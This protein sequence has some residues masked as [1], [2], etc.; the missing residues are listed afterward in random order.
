MDSKRRKTGDQDV[1][2]LRLASRQKYLAEREAQQ[3]ALLRRQVAEEA[4]EEARLGNKLSERERAE[5][6][7]NRQTLELAE[8]RN[9]IDDSR[10]QDGFHFQTDSDNP[11]LEGTA[12]KNDVLYRR[13]NDAYDSRPQ[14]DNSN[15]YMSGPNIPQ[16]QDQDNMYEYVFDTAN[17]VRFTAEDV[18]RMDPAKQALEAQLNAAEKRSLSIQETRQSLPIFKYRQELLDAVANH[19]T[20][21]MVGDTGSGKSTQ[22]VQ[23]LAEAGYTKTGKICVT[24]PRRVAAMSVAKR[25]AEEYG[26]KIG[27]EVGFAVRFEDKTSEKTV[28]KFATD[29]ILLREVMAD[30]LLMQYSVIMIDEA[31][32]RSIASDL[33]LCLCREVCRA[34]PEFKLLILSATINATEFSEYF[35]RAPCFFVEGRNFPIDIRYTVAP[36]ANYLAAACTTALQIHLASPLDHGMGGILIFL[37]GEEEILAAVE[38]LETTMKKLGS[39]VPELIVRP[40]YSALSSDAQA[41]VFEPTPPNARL[42][43]VSTNIAETSLTIDGIKHVIDCGY[44]KAQT[45]DPVSNVSS[46]TISPISRASANQRSGRAGRT[47]HGY[48]Y[49]LYTKHAF[50]NELPEQTEPELLRSNLD[51]VVLTLKALNIDNLLEFEFFTAPSPSS[52]IRSLESLYSLAALDSTG[53]LTKLGR[54]MAELPLDIRLSKM[55]LESERY[56]CQQQVLSIISVL[57]EASSLF[58][59]PKDKKVAADAARARFSSTEGGD[60][61][62]YLNIW[63]QYEES[64]FDSRWATENFLQWRCLSRARNV[65][66]QLQ[67]L[68]DRVEVPYSSCGSTDHVAIR[69]CIT[70]AYFGNAARL[71]RDGLSYRTVSNNGMTV[72]I[73]PSSSLIENRPK[74]IVFYEIVESSKTYVRSVLPIQPEWLVEV[75]PH[76]HTES[77][78]S[79]LGDNK[80]MPKATA[81]M[82]KER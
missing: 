40:L 27:N 47:S 35:D 33:L 42:V 23:Y 15:D 76:M 32:E 2:A 67:N 22:M 62:T 38:N 75:A 59:R 13:H 41:K 16:P 58:L 17:E 71:A 26:C 44:E 78:I 74:W 51:G 55:V 4:E 81:K 29:G 11:L 82:L 43:V 56:Q 68:C 63:N 80:K 45:Y 25:V 14:H 9:A 1:S 57:S 19:Q 21:V 65:R 61:M 72:F 10:L 6:K 8:A 64:G 18:A 3:L 70:S 39:R 49:R 60:F 31:H 36:E 66:D 79:K 54:R 52:M 53:R 50:Y 5:F 46:L 24:Q 73:H 28:M 20:L 69:K 37:T 12:S 30:P 77:S 48:A 7:K 34:R